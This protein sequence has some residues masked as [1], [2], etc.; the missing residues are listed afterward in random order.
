MKARIHLDSQGPEHAESNPHRDF[1]LVLRN[2][3]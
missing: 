1:V 2:D 3:R